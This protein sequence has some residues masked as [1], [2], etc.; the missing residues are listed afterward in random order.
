MASDKRRRSRVGTGFDAVVSCGGLEN[1]PVRVKNLSLKGMLCAPE[2][3]I[4]T[5]QDCT[6]IVE[7][8]EAI[9]F[10]IEA[11]MIRNDEKGL[12]LDFEGMDEKAFFH[13]R[14]LVRYH[15]H[16]PDSID[17]ELAVPAFTARKPR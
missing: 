6:I 13:L 5:L 7:L 16:D 14:N 10:R 12:A 1:F 11:R 4:G 15:S 9:V 8:T 2:P 17:Q 3:R